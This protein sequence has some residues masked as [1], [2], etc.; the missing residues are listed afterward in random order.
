VYICRCRGFTILEVL[1][2]VTIIAI[3]AA[4]AIPNLLSAQFRAKVA[5][6]ANDLRTA[7]TALEA[8]R[9]DHNA[10]PPTPL[11][12]PAVLTVIPTRLSTPTAY[13]TTAQLPDI[14]MEQ[15]VPEYYGLNSEGNLRQYS[16]RPP[17]PEG[18][19]PIAGRRYYYQ[20]LDDA[21]RGENARRNLGRRIPFNGLWEL[22]S[23]GPNG[24]RDTGDIDGDG[25][26][27]RTMHIPYDPT[28]GSKSAGNIV[29]T[30]KS[31]EGK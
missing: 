6:A 15:I 17:E 12:E 25:P 5:R 23:V 26:M 10:Y 3:L 24:K 11:V 18:A 19:D 16:E 9:V 30:A 29:R 20:L 22:A 31:S 8:Y 1:I 28:N 7:A 14:F 13:I 27:P 2:A 4:I 21:R